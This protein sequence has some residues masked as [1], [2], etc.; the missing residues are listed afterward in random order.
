MNSSALT[1]IAARPPPA[2]PMVT[3]RGEGA[4]AW[5]PH[6]LSITG[7][8]GKAAG[9]VERVLAQHGHENTQPAIDHTA[10]RPAVTMTAR[11]EVTV[12]RG[13][14]GVVLHTGAAPVI[15]GPRSR[16][17]QARRIE[18]ARRLPL[19]MVTGAVPRCARSRA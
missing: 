9:I 7:V 11:A 3:R 1:P 2:G 10:E 13:A 4:G 14:G 5:I 17:L 16:R 19:A 18:T 15:R 12:V 6:R 8:D